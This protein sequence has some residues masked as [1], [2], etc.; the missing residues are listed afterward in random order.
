ME[1]D[2]T[3]CKPSSPLEQKMVDT[4]I[5]WCWLYY[6]GQLCFADINYQASLVANRVMV[7][8]HYCQTKA[9]NGIVEKTVPYRSDRFQ[10][11]N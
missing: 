2:I 6:C 4:G 8:I 9:L 10:L 1:I 7:D 11:E 3:T 5:A